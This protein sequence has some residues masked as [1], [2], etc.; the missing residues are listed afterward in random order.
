MSEEK[1]EIVKK[2]FSFTFIFSRK[3]DTWKIPV[4]GNFEITGKFEAGRLLKCR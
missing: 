4:I 2:I 1:S 3:I